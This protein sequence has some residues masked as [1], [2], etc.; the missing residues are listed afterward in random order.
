MLRD[1]RHAPPGKLSPNRQSA[2]LPTREA[3]RDIVLG[4]TW[5]AVLPE[6]EVG[7]VAA[8]MIVRDLPG[9]GYACRKEEEV[10]GWIGVLDGLVKVA[11][12]SPSGKTITFAGIPSG[13]WFGEGT[14]L[15]D[16]R[17]KFDAI[18]IRPSRIAIVPR[19]TFMR[20]IETSIP[21]NRFLIEQLNARLGH[22]IG[23][24]E[25]DRLLGP[26]A[27]VARCIA[28]LFNTALYPDVKSTL[29]ISQEEV[30]YLCALSRQ[31]VNRALRV[32]ESEGLLRV[33]YGRITALDLDR[34]RRY[35]G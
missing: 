10:L 1:Y 7:R 6:A 12:A 4:T 14:V 8:E 16:R 18:A 28:S 21:F 15:K 5:G 13:G 22:F 17:W 11:S 9:G 29:A 25:F 35:E 19:A 27:R 2:A 3:I 23:L 34:L 32:L 33:D 31:R 26:D 24:V 20:L 30:G